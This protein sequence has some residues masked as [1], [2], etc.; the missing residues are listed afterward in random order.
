MVF[1]YPEGTPSR[2]S[3]RRQR[4]HRQVNCSAP[5]GRPMG[6]PKSSIFPGIC[7]QI[8]NPSLL[9]LKV[10]FFRINGR[11]MQLRKRHN[12]CPTLE[13]QS[14]CAVV[15]PFWVTGRCTFGLLE[16]LGAPCFSFHWIAVLFLVLQKLFFNVPPLKSP[17]P[18]AALIKES[19]SCPF[20]Y[21]KTPCLLP[22]SVRSVLNLWKPTATQL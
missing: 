13:T 9:G 12:E 15:S 10:S 2:S 8:H 1:F 5:L 6:F 4:R 11:C 22:L 18:R 3:G 21:W 16:R 17:H 14:G 19:L 7:L 20:F